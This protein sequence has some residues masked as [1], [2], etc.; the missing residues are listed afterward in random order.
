[1]GHVLAHEL[2]HVLQ[3]FTHHSK[4]GVMKARWDN[5][6]LEQMARQPLSF[7][8][9]DAAAIRSGLAKILAR[10]TGR[11]ADPAERR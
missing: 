10:S 11:P 1:L 5:G 2:A 7:S 9:E 3:G 4:A 6:D 8:A